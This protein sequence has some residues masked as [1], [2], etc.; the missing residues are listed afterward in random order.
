M[1][2]TV[3]IKSPCHL[4]VRDGCLLVRRKGKDEA[5]ALVPLDDVWVIIVDN[6][7]VTL[8]A[9]LIS[10]V[11]DAGIGILFCAAN[12]MPNGLCLPLGAHSRHAEIVENQL[13]ISKPLRKRLWRGIV[14]QKVANQAIVAEMLGQMGCSRRLLGL[15]D[16]VRSGDAGNVEAV[17]ASDYFKSV[18]PEGTRRDGPY[19]RPLDF[20]Y[21]I[22]RAGIAQVAVSHGWLVSRGINHHS[23]ENAFNLVDDLIEPFRPL[24]DLVVLG[25]G[26]TDPLGPPEKSRLASQLNM[27]VNIDGRRQ[28]LR[29]A[30]DVEVES[31]RR[32]VTLDD[33]DQLLLPTVVGTDAVTSASE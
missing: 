3:S 28:S 27:V 10:Q 15:V 30:I 2:R 24:T 13:A 1:K 20:G 4:S 12:G 32:A 21:H 23:A 8:T 11:N 5:G 19:A 16:K 9:P 33:A 26:L 18:L 17:A 25:D 22:L 29:A 31:F 7:Q 14:R 6:P